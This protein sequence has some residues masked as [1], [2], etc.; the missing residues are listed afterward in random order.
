MDCE[1][2]GFHD[3]ILA[4]GGRLMLLGLSENC[5][6]AEGSSMDAI[7]DLVALGD[8][9]FQLLINQKNQRVNEGRRR[10]PSSS[11]DRGACS[12]H[13]KKHCQSAVFFNYLYLV[14]WHQ[15]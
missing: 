3:F 14:R 2:C 6:N 1:N 12:E 13:S 7:K 10:L 15:A 4:I 11:G 5:Q 9:G 8:E